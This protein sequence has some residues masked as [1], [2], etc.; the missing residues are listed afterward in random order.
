MALSTPTISECTSGSS[1]SGSFACYTWTFN[2]QPD[3]C[4]INMD[5]ESAW[6]APSD[7]SHPWP[8]YGVSLVPKHK[9]EETSIRVNFRFSQAWISSAHSILGKKREE[10]Q[11][12]RAQRL[13]YSL[14]KTWS[15]RSNWS[16]A[17]CVGGFGSV[18]AGTK[19]ER[20]LF[21]LVLLWQQES[22]IHDN[23]LPNSV[24]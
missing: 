24:K 21:W 6:T 18:W 7:M 9:C 5:P 19:G 11:Q 16:Y 8:Y 22:H 13:T 2:R 23:R 4:L 15:A 17:Q 14:A 20:A 1:T 10:I 12:L 3:Y